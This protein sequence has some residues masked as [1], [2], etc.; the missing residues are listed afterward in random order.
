MTITLLFTL[1][2]IL[3]LVGI[4]GC[5]LPIIPGPP[6]SFLAL[7]IQQL[8]EVPPFTTNFLVTWGLLVLVVSVLDY[9]IPVYGAKKAGGSRLGTWGCALGLVFGLWGGPLGIIVGPFIG[10]FIGE[11]IATTSVQM[12]LRASVATFV[13]FLLG[14]LLKLGVCLVMAWHLVSVMYA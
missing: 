14:T 8:N 10:A 7:M 6:I 1:G 5:F 13:G 2:A 12:A 9:V 4:A 3:M 11:L